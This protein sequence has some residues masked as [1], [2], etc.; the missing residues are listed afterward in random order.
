MKDIK[1]TLRALVTSP[2]TSDEGPTETLPLWRNVARR[3]WRSYLIPP[4]GGAI[5]AYGFLQACCRTLVPLYVYSGEGRDWR[6]VL[7]AVGVDYVAL[8]LLVMGGAVAVYGAWR[9]HGSMKAV[10]GTRV[11]HDMGANRRN[12]LIAENALLLLA[13]LWVGV[14]PVVVIFASALAAARSGMMGEDVATP[15]WASA[16]V[17]VATFLA[18]LL[19]EVVMT[20]ARLTF[21]ELTECNV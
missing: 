8:V 18:L 3:T 4:L 1:N 21:R 14:L 17:G 10:V 6:R 11:R 20:F 13:A 5:C 7:A 15:L 9:A 19:L 16:G 2:A 12:L